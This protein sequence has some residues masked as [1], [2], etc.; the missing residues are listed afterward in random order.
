MTAGPH[1]RGGTPG[2][3]GA[4]GSAAGAS[5]GELTLPPGLAG[6]LGPVRRVLF[7]GKSMSRSRCSG[8]LVDALQRHGVEVRWRNPVTL[9]RWFGQSFAMRV[10]RREFRRFAPDLV[11]V[12]FRDLPPVLADEFRR[13]ARLVIWC[14]EALEVLDGSI[15]D[16]FGLAD[17]VCMSNP[18]RFPWLRE[19]GLD[20]MTFL[21]SGF[22]PRYHRPAPAQRFRRDV[23]FIGGPGRRGQRASFLA[24]V[25]KRFQTD[26]FGRHWERWRSLH[27]GLRVHGPIDNRG[28]AAICATS[29]IVLGVNEVND[30]P[31]YFSNRTFLTLACGAFHLTHYVPRLEDVF[32][33]GEHLVWYRD[34]DEALAKIEHWLQRD[35]ERARIAAGGHA[36]VM[37]HHQYFHR[38]ARILGWL[39][40]GL[41]RCEVPD[42]TA[43]SRAAARPAPPA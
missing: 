32:R 16:Y 15:V 36:E 18:A 3:A 24:E 6:R 43:P 11:F 19:R 34:E 42:H 25:A 40:H 5:P 8:A 30:D 33:D 35:D 4:A 26:V 41:P 9:R 10:V 27:P 23:A 31:F 38:V 13:D 28:Y 2:G 37:E 20:N 22:S 7:F 17:L 21:M 12:F 39:Q 14:E 29:R 1:D